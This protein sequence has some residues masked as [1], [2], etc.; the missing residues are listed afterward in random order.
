APP[1]IVV[2]EPTP[3]DVEQPM[4]LCMSDNESTVTILRQMFGARLE[5]V[6]TADQ[7]EALDLIKFSN[8]AAVIFDMAPEHFMAGLE[9]LHFQCRAQDVPLIAIT[10]NRQ[11]AAVAHAMSAGVVHC[12]VKPLSVEKLYHCAH[13]TIERGRQVV[14]VA[15][16]DI[17]VREMITN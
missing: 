16:D 4:M 12:V 2:E 9:A 6:A 8:P 3:R 10:P 15:D 14:L 5:I 11:A 17:I 7:V 13:T 1:P